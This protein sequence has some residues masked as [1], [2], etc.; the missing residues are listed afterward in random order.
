MK[1]FALDE[2]GKPGSVRDLPDP[3]PEEGQVRVRV[4]AAG[5]NP[6]DNAVVQGYMKDSME[7]RFP[8]VP[9]MDAS[10][11]VDMVGPGV[12][13]LSVGDEVFGGV[14][15]S[16]LGGGTFAE[17]ATMSVG[18]VAR[19]PP[20]I[21]HTAAAAV[22]VA[23][24][25]AVTLLDAIGAGE[26]DVIVA[27]GATGGVGS[28][29]L[30]LAARRGI[31]VVAVCSAANADY[32]RSLGAVEVIDYEAGDVADAVRSRFPEGVAGIADMHGDAEAVTK[33][34]AA[35]REGGHVA[36]AVGAADE[37]AL[38]ARGIG[39]TNVFGRVTTASLEALAAEIEA[40][41][42]VVPELHTFPLDD[43]QRALDQVASG[44]T[45]GKIV[46]EI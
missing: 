25:T 27:L 46:L 2:L 18:T 30:Q 19:K 40:K 16:F 22:P 44:H 34:A 35:V 39:A 6:F 11:T 8:L 10:G 9:G 43:A 41:A 4:A 29:L 5:V 28:F 1:A 37:T 20:S 12:T 32:A 17:L 24:V 36:S 31:R 42:I 15:K 7:H 26:G 14:G 23:G 13:D 21:E 45:R 38:G 3:E 33:V